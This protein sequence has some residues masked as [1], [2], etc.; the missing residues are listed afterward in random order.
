M[1]WFNEYFL[2]AAAAVLGLFMLLALLRAILGPRTADR[3]MGINMIGTLVILMLA[4]L[5]V[6]LKQNWLLD[7]S[8]LYAAISFLSVA[9]L[10][11]LTIAGRSR[12]TKQ[13]Q[14]KEETH[15]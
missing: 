10:C 15:D 6:L 1:S 11:I 13:E 5:A 4:L 8:I 14:E 3:V 9:V 7:V 12:R 2:P